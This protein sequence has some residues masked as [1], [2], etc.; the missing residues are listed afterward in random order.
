M[1]SMNWLVLGYGY[2]LKTLWRCLGDYYKFLEYN[3]H[4]YITL[5]ITYK[6]DFQSSIALT[7][8]SILIS[9]L[10]ILSPFSN[11][12][13]NFFFDLSRRLAHKYDLLSS[14]RDEA[15]LPTRPS[16]KYAPRTSGRRHLCTWEPEEA[17]KSSKISS[18]LFR[19]FIWYFYRSLSIW[20]FEVEYSTWFHIICIKFFSFLVHLFFFLLFSKFFLSP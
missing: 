15:I 16:Q 18:G 3:I 14:N 6:L 20:K 17:P 10:S 7:W 9:S 11:D 12:Y 13:E 2:F 5:L 1:Y 19:S 4:F 8:S